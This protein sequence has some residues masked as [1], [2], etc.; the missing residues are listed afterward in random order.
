MAWDNVWKKAQKVSHISYKHNVR[1]MFHHQ[2]FWLVHREKELCEGFFRL[3]YYFNNIFS[4]INF[5][6]DVIIVHDLHCIIF[7][8]LFILN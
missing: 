1:I 7:A 5:S 2:I 8:V 6:S 4:D 3:V